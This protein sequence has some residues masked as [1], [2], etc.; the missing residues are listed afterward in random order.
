LEAFI[1][2]MEEGAPCA[3]TLKYLRFTELLPKHF[4]GLRRALPNILIECHLMSKGDCYASNVIVLDDDDFG[5]KDDFD[6]DDEV[7]GKGT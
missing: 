2:A 3:R 5:S 1:S 7:Q 6:S 4:E